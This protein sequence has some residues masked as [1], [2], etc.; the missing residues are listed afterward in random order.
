MFLYSN[1]QDASCMEK[2]PA[3]EHKTQEISVNEGL[4]KCIEKSAEFFLLAKDMILEST[5]DSYEL[6]HKA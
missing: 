6:N 2:R 5:G 1:K 3:Q 4:T